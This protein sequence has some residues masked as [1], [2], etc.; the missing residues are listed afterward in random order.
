MVTNDND[1]FKKFFG[2]GGSGD[3]DAATDGTNE[4]VLSEKEQLDKANAAVAEW[5]EKYLSLT[6]DFQTIKNV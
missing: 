4:P 3:S 5:A 1:K 2:F 6:A